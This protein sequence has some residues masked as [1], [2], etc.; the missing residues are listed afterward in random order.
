MRTLLALFGSACVLAVVVAFYALYHSDAGGG[1]GARVETAIAELQVTS[2][3]LEEQ[4]REL[5][6]GVAALVD[7]VEGLRAASRESVVTESPAERSPADLEPE[8][9][10]ELVARLEEVA[11]QLEEVGSR[12]QGVLVAG[13]P[14][15]E[16]EE[17]RARTVAESQ[18]IATDRTVP[19]VERLAALRQLRGRGG[20]SHE[21]TLA[22][23]ELIQDPSID[24]RTRADIIRNLHGVDFEELKQPLVNVLESDGSAEV[25]SET[26]ETLDVFY[27]DPAVFQAVAHVRDNDP[28]FRVRMEATQRLQMHQQMRAT[29]APTGR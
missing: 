21:V 11:T 3:S 1:A 20:R 6:G 25:R 10:R 7:A 26:I 22:M 18:G 19:S 24:G 12:S 4:V 9:L 29:V 16:T 13:R 23:I 27:D 8:G 14:V 15:V 17:E 2:S 5:T 28:D